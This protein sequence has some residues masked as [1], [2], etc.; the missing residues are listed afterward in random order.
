MCKDRAFSTANNDNA[1]S[2][3]V[4]INWLGHDRWLCGYVQQL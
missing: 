4:L 3:L 2:L 1:S